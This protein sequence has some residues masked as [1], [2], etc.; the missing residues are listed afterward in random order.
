MAKEG[1]D[2]GGGGAVFGAAFEPCAFVELQE[3][4]GKV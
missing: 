4:R 3:F 2:G 1:C